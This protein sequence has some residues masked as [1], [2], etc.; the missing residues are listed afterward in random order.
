PTGATG[1]AGAAGPT[2][3]TGPAGVAGPTGATGP[4]GAAGPTGATG[5]AG[6]AGPTGATGPAGATGP[7]GPSGLPSVAA[8]FYDQPTTT[9]AIPLG[10]ETTVNTVSLPV[11]AGNEIKIDT[12][13]QVAVVTTANWALSFNIN[14]R[15]NGT[16][17]TQQTIARSGNTAGTQRFIGSISFVDVAPATGTDTYTVSIQTTIATSVTSATSEQRLINI[18]RFV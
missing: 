18:T 14:I 15:R 3:A 9:L 5:P 4:A 1:P 13:Q 6:V 2:G 17:I 12:S 8:L 16:L 11:T 10:T 7:T